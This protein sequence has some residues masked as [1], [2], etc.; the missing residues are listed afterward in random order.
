[1]IEVFK[2]NVQDISTAKKV[3]QALTKALG[4]SIVSFDLEDCDSIL[5]IEAASICS[6]CV[7][8]LLRTLE[9]ECEVLPG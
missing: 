3:E 2:T 8:H 1:M 9:C 5:R 6:A 7:I 4:Y